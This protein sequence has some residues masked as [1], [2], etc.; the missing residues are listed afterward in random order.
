[1]QF[2][3]IHSCRLCALM[4]MHVHLTFR[5][6]KNN[7]VCHCMHIIIRSCSEN[8]GRQWE[9]EEYLIDSNVCGRT[10]RHIDRTEKAFSRKIREED[11]CSVWRLR[12]F[13]RDGTTEPTMSKPSKNVTWRD[14]PRHHVI[15]SPMYVYTHIWGHYILTSSFF[16]AITSRVHYLHLFLSVAISQTYS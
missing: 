15:C 7:G 9:R 3:K 16:I 2:L 14:L 13:S 8:C 5:K 6:Q 1:M 4:V 11:S 12:L 10:L